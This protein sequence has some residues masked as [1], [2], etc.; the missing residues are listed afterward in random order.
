MSDIENRRREWERQNPGQ[1]FSDIHGPWRNDPPPKYEDTADW[2][3][4]ANKAI[5]A[6]LLQEGVPAWV[7]DGVS[8]V[9]QMLAAQA[10]A[11]RTAIANVITAYNNA[12]PV[13]TADVHKYECTCLRCAIDRLELH[14]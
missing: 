1:T 11:P 8:I 5:E 7:G 10:K 13:R 4:R 14:L 6:A 3:Y 2:W 12:N 9:A